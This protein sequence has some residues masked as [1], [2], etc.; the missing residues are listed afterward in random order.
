[1]GLLLQSDGR[2]C[3]PRGCVVAEVMGVMRSEACGPRRAG[4]E[5]SGYCDDLSVG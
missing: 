2:G 5:A 1:M 3:S 4:G